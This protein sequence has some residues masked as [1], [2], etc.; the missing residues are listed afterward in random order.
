MTATCLLDLKNG[1]GMFVP[2]RLYIQAHKMITWMD[3]ENNHH[4][5]Q[6]V[7]AL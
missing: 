5:V 7:V 2:L 1:N 3:C 4:Q 6:T